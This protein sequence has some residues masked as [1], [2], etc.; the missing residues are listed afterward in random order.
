MAADRDLSSFVPVEWAQK[1]FT[2]R[3]RT[4]TKTYLLGGLGYRLTDYAFHAVKLVLFVL[5]WIFFCRF[6]PG[7]GTAANFATWIFEPAAFRSGQFVVNLTL[8]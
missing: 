7:L 2:E 3:V 6:T 8:V 5:G 1:G 4:A